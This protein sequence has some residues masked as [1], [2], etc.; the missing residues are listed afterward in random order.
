MTLADIMYTLFH[1]YHWI[2]VMG[3]RTP[4]EQ[5]RPLLKPWLDLWQCTS[6][7]LSVPLDYVMHH[8]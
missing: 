4:I 8:M 5:V 3:V 2:R 6:S 7:L 1:D